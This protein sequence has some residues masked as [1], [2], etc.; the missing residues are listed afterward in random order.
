MNERKSPT[1]PGARATT[2][3][4]AIVRALRRADG[5]RSAQDLHIDLRGQGEQVGL[6]TVYRNLQALVEAGEIDVLHTADGE[7]IY[8]LCDSDDHHHHL[9]CR[10]CGL[11]VEI[12]NR[13]FEE[14]VDRT[15]HRHGFSSISHTAAVY[16]ECLA[17]SRRETKT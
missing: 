14:W 4:A 17:C 1:L 12:A 13:E 6:T 10:S 9:V 11:S 15:A 2:Q 5:F 8:R 3:R 16:G 7:A